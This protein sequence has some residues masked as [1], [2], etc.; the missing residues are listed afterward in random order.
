MRYQQQLLL[1]CFDFQ[2]LRSRLGKL[3]ALLMKNQAVLQVSG[4]G[5]IDGLEKRCREEIASVGENFKKQLHGLFRA[6]TLPEADAAILERTAK[7]SAYFEDKIT[8][9][10]VPLVATIQIDT[11][12]KEIRKKAKDALKQLRRR[13]RSSRP[14]S[15]PAGAVFRRRRTCGRSRLPRSS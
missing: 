5:E 13:R 4:A 15:H 9:I 1:E 6:D 8:S 14:P 10:L 2:Y 11:D 3:V 12:N 7:A